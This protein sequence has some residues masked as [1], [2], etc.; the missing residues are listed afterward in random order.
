MPIP[1]QPVRFPP[2]VK[3]S[4]DFERLVM[5]VNDRGE[6]KP[7][8]FRHMLQN[9]LDQIGLAIYDDHDWDHQCFTP[10]GGDVP[11]KSVEKLTIAKIA[12]AR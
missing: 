6:F 1:T 2:W 5:I 8:L 9:T 11:F 10:A 12:L 3:F 4:F 7:S